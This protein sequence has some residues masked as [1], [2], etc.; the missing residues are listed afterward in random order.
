MKKIAFLLLFFTLIFSFQ[1]C[2]TQHQ[3]KSE[4]QVE[5]KPIEV[6][7]IH[8]IIDVNIKIDKELDSFFDEIDSE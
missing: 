4:S 8:I 6:K 1:A 2:T 5:V 7:P 3:V